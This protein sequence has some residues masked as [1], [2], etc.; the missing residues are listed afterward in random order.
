MS[1]GGIFVFGVFA[2]ALLAGGIVFTIIE[3]NRM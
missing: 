3:F 1:D 2:M